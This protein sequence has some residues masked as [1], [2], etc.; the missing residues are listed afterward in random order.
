[1]VSHYGQR[2]KVCDTSVGIAVHASEALVEFGAPPGM[3]FDLMLLRTRCRGGRFPRQDFHPASASSSGRNLAPVD[4]RPR[5]VL[6]FRQEPIS[7]M[8]KRYIPL[9]ALACLLAYAG[10]IEPYWISRTFYDV[11]VEGLW[12]EGL[13]VVHIADI[14]AKR[15]GFREKKTVEMVNQLAPDYVFV[16]GD[17]L[18]SER[19]VRGGLAF[20]AGLR[21]K[22]GVYAVL[23]N[24]DGALVDSIVRGK[25][26]QAASGY[27]IL[28]NE[29]VDCGIFTL[30][31]LD[32]PVTYRKDIGRAFAGVSGT[33]PIIVL[34]HFHPLDLIWEMKA[35]GV[36][37]MFSGHT[38]GGQIGFARLVGLVPYAA[39]SKYMAGLYTID[40]L[41]LCVTR[42]IGINIFPFRFLCRPEIV[43]VRMRGRQS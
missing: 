25:I 28:L 10:L 1:M 8:K 5:P 21:A 27:R 33:K 4:H 37:L 39:R 32:D 34:S 36:D 9:I 13:T 26:P 14:H 3:V 30:V 40:G 22:R 24:A 17:L 7:N 20:L 16:T 29:S 19:K 12:S 41:Q 43:V 6:A 23:G 11:E 2:C 35:R 31:G 38:H 18:K 15:L 42:G